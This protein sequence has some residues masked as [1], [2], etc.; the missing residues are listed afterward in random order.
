VSNVQKISSWFERAL[1]NPKHSASRIPPHQ[2]TGKTLRE[3]IARLATYPQ[4]PARKPKPK[5]ETMHSIK[6]FH[7]L[8]MQGLTHQ[9]AADQLGKDLKTLEKQYYRYPEYR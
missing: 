3:V 1:D 4:K 7:R 2:R 9:E 5:P 8:I 6:N